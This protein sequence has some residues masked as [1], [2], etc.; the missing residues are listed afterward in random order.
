[1]PYDIT[2]THKTTIEELK[3]LKKILEIYKDIPVMVEVVKVK[4]RDKG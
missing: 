4:K 1:M 2:I 3:E